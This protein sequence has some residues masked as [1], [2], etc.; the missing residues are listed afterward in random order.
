[1]AREI[2]PN[3]REASSLRWKALLLSSIHISSYPNQMKG[4]ECIQCRF[5]D[6]FKSLSC[7]AAALDPILMILPE[8]LHLC[9]WMDSHKNL[10][11]ILSVHVQDHQMRNRAKVKVKVERVNMEIAF[12]VISQPPMGTKLL[13]ALRLLSYLMNEVMM[14]S[15][16]S[17]IRL[18]QLHLR[19]HEMGF[20]VWE[21]SS[22]RCLPNINSAVL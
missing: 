22:F 16:S 21:T 15:S 7:D 14:K 8:C 12:S 17:W 3:S 9:V 18:W 5:N 1:M 4:S 6:P 10:R 19:L 11:T 2:A 13:K 20:C